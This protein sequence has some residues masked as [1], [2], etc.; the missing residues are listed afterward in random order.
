V[1]IILAQ[2]SHVAQMVDL[3]EEF[4]RFHEPFDPRYPLADNVRAGYEMYLRELMQAEN[5]KVLAAIGGGQVAGY[6]IAAIRKPSPAFKREK[7]GYI[8]E[9]AV[10]ASSRRHGVGSVMLKQ[11]FDW[12]KAENLDMIELSVAAKNKIGYSFWKKHGFRDYL[13]HLYLKP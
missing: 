12:F 1:E 13:H 3:W 9:M 7:I 10:T 11:V 8:E 6:V 2:E 4:M 5:T